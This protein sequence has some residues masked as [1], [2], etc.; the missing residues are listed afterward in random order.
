MNRWLV[1]LLAGLM[2]VSLVAVGIWFYTNF[3]RVEEMVDVGFKGEA[4]TNPFL[5]AQRF[6]NSRDSPTKSMVTLAGLPRIDGTLVIAGQR[7][8]VGPERAGELLGWVNAGGHL[9]VTADTGLG[10]ERSVAEDWLLDR[11]GVSAT[12]VPVELPLLP[13]DVDIPEADDYL[14]VMFAPSRVLRS[15]AAGPERR[16]GGEYGD[17]VL[18]YQLGK[19]VLTV[20]SDTAF[21]RNRSIGCYDNAAFL[22]H[23]TH[24]QRNGE[25]WLVYGG[26][27]PPLWK[28]LWQHAWVVIV[29]ATVL[30]LAWVAMHRRRFGPLSAAP[31]LA[32]RR[33]LDHI[34]ASGHFLW[35][36]GQQTT[37][38]KAARDALKQTLIKRH[39]VWSGAS[40]V[41]LSGFLAERIG[42][43]PTRVQQALFEPYPTHEHTFTEAISLLETIR[44]TL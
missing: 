16:L 29:S 15:R 42:A 13:T 7:F 9:V 11:L 23:L 1:L 3:A 43:D 17:H 14:Q 10:S 34:K 33:L 32:R 35:R 26:D 20:L 31:T 8:N 6:L 25:I 28:W 19:G 39:P 27:M 36:N 12:T 30:L 38:L 44:K 5:A 24:F 2:A 4:R 37:L 18:H 21:M 41:A 40:P 22:W